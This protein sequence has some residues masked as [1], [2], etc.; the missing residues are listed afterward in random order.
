MSILRIVPFEYFKVIVNVDF[1]VAI[2]E[3]VTVSPRFTSF[4]VFPI[5]TLMTCEISLF[6]DCEILKLIVFS[7]PPESLKINSVL[8]SF[9]ILGTFDVN[10]ILPSLS[11]FIV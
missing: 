10:K 1:G 2:P 8:S 6:S 5:D 9:C 4:G 11:T 3:R 7:L